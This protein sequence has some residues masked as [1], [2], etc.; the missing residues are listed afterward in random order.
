MCLLK[1]FLL[2]RCIT[3]NWLGGVAVLV[4]FFSLFIN[5]VIHHRD[6]TCARAAGNPRIGGSHGA[7]PLY[8]Y[9]QLYC[10]VLVEVPDTTLDACFQY[11]SGRL[12]LSITMLEKA[13]LVGY[14]FSNI[15]QSQ[16]CYNV[17]YQMYMYIIYIITVPN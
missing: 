7:Q 10:V 4:V 8:Y 9:M 6:T 3:Y 17:L 2:P 1:F 15:Y 12:F 13:V 5:T 14:Q 11:L 16:R